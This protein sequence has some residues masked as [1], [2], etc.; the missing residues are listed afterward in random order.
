ML[1]IHKRIEKNLSKNSLSV[2]ASDVHLSGEPMRAY[3]ILASVFLAC[4]TPDP[5][6]PQ[7]PIATPPAS[8]P[9]PEKIT[10][11]VDITESPT[12]PPLNKLVR[13]ALEARG[14][15][16]TL[17]ALDVLA[18]QREKNKKAWIHE[19][20]E[21]TAD[22]ALGLSFRVGVSFIVQGSLRDGAPPSLYL[23][24]LDAGLGQPIWRAEI[25]VED[26]PAKAAEI[27][28]AQ[29]IEELILNTKP[30]PRYPT[31]M[32]KL[33]LVVSPRHGELTYQAIEALMKELPRK[34]RGL[35]EPRLVEFS[36]RGATLEVLYHLDIKWLRQELGY[37]D[38]I[39][40]VT[41]VTKEQVHLE[42]K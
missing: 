3:L 16:E 6:M 2:G 30:Y 9:A 11:F 36:S 7:A 24:V 29:L 32:K 38:A 33:S 26:T 42:L 20:Y 22:D 13:D 5:K 27:L 10:L 1:R 34:V 41:S 28:V 23:S 21:Y 37:V 40:R 15:C 35:F 18:R 4:A 8:Q 12:D 39:E 17:T 14:C 25:L 19:S 31:E